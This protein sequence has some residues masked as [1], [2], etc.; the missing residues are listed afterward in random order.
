[1]KAKPLA[2]EAAESELI[3]DL[4][5]VA[6]L[7]V[8]ATEDFSGYTRIL[9]FDP[10]ADGFVFDLQLAKQLHRTM[11]LLEFIRKRILNNKAKHFD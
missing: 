5:S 11:N 9:N 10:D 4:A 8:S 6:D 3:Q 2:V 1:M 7:K